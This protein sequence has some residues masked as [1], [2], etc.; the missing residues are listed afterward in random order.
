ME[1][2]KPRQMKEQ[3]AEM[4]KAEKERKDQIAKDE[5]ELEKSGEIQRETQAMEKYLADKKINAQKA[6]KGT[7]VYIKEKGNG[8]AAAAGKFVKVKYTGYFLRT[9]SVFQSN[10]YA[11]QLG[12][13]GVIRGWDDGLQLFN[14]GG[15]GVLYVPGFAAYG[16][17]PPPN[18]PFKPFDPLKFDVEILQVSD[19]PIQ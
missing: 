16:K 1:K 12:V 7:Y 19:S 15:K 10:E 2:D 4:E 14:Q 11:F 18:S 5:M 13:G 9:D 6:G 17:N 8:P 3:Q